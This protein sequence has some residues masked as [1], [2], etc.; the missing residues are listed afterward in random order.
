MQA[1]DLYQIPETQP[2]RFLHVPQGAEPGDIYEFG[3]GQARWAYDNSPR[4]PVL[5]ID[6]DT[7]DGVTYV[8]EPT[9]MT[10]EGA[11]SEEGVGFISMAIVE[12]QE[13][14]PKGYHIPGRL[15]IQIL[16]RS[17]THGY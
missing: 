17:E 16:V 12:R 9:F 3:N 7:D 2:I 5:A 4:H 14:G 8:A 11:D 1:T 15:E 13:Q 10:D 6:L